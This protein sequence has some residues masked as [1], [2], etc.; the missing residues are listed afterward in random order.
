M[1]AHA[2]RRPQ[3]AVRRRTL[4]RR[5]AAATALAACALFGLPTSAPAKAKPRWNVLL[6]TIDT[7]RTDRLSCYGFDHVRTENVDRLAARGTIFSRA[8]AHTPT[9]L[10]SHA[11]IMVG[12]TPLTHGVHDNS[13]F[14]VRPEMLTLAEH[15]KA[16]GYATAAFVGAYP[17]DS[18]FGLDQGFDLYDDDFGS[19]SA[20]GD[21]FYVER[22]AEAVVG[23]AM[24]WL[25]AA[26]ASPWF[27]WV[28]CFDPHEPY[29][30]PAPYDRSFAQSPYDGEVAYVDAALGA[31]FSWL[32]E[33]GLAGRT[34]VV[35][36][37]DHGESLGEHGEATHAYF[38]YNA[39]IWV[40]LI[41][42]SP[43][44]RPGRSDAGVAHMDIFPTVCDAL[45]V[46][47]PRGLPGLSLMPA[48]RGKAFPERSLYFESLYPYYSRGWAP[49]RGV[50]QD[51]KKYIESPIPELYDLDRDFAELENLAGRVR[52]DGLRASL[53]KWMK[54]A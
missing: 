35:L 16:E 12:A 6:V 15:L 45:G 14:V 47:P 34:L 18:R 17:L 37:A 32:E 36:T 50:I 1:S 9:T 10:P 29:R 49:L 40:P 8:F 39:T 27:V 30:P 4:V 5:T 23:R 33:T 13:G 43:G 48:V 51:R 52:W 53:A 19:Q 25:K 42:L 41:V 44:G 11:N 2:G 7:L 20:R 28:H 31:L 54:S 24:G 38:A 46:K 3:P 26:P 21:A 22:S